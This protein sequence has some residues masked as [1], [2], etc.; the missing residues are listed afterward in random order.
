[1]N[2]SQ[3]IKLNI[4][5][6][7]IV[8]C[9]L[10]VNGCAPKVTSTIQINTVPEGA[11][12]TV[13]GT[14]SGESPVSFLHKYAVTNDDNKIDIDLEKEGYYPT[15]RTI[16]PF[17]LISRIQKKD[18]IRGSNIGKG[19]TI[20]FE[21]YLKPD[22]SAAEWNEIKTSGDLEKLENFLKKYP[23]TT[24]LP[25]AR[26][27]ISPFVIDRE[28]DDIEHIEEMLNSSDEFKN[29]NLPNYLA[30]L[31]IIKA[32]NVKIKKFSSGGE[33][34]F[35][36]KKDDKKMVPVTSEKFKVIKLH[37]L[38]GNT[39]NI[40]AWKNNRTFD[41]GLAYLKDG[42]FVLIVPKEDLPIELEFPDVLYNRVVVKE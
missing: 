5:P 11:K 22:K 35:Y 31:E 18:Y 32:H 12:V 2:P 3:N 25:E 26:K 28:K 23:D 15:S 42:S 9:F 6:C 7:I 1:M 10:L 34:L 40:I 8:L 30:R 16:W 21:I 29:R 14:Y 37:D 24:F 13:D 38:P 17:G 19:D 36:Q 33:K 27:A 4:I 20:P 41:A 39:T